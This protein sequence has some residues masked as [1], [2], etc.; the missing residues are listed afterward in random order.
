M[1]DFATQLIE[2][3]DRVEEL[4]GNMTEPTV[5]VIREHDIVFGIWRDVEAP[6]GIGLELIKG[7]RMILGGPNNPRAVTTAVWVKDHADAI[8][9]RRALGEL[10]A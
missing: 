1:T 10:D 4:T 8:L 9:A 2:E 5:E 6:F 3:A 7:K